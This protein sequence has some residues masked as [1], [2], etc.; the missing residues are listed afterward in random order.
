MHFWVWNGCMFVSSM[1]SIPVGQ[2]D[3]HGA[4]NAKVMGLIV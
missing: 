3:V 4:H 2:T 1:G